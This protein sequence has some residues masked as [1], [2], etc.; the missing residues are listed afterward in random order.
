MVSIN[1]AETI[2][3]VKMGMELKRRT[4]FFSALTIQTN[5][6]MWTERSR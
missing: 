5:F 6:M 2:E 3:A 1:T 4:D